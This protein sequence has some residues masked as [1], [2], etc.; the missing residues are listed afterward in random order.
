MGVIF[1]SLLLL[2]RASH[3]DND[4]VSFPNRD[5]S[6][7]VGGAASRVIYTYYGRAARKTEYKT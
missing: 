5:S 4:I 6:T 1:Y 2:L 3:S 7:K